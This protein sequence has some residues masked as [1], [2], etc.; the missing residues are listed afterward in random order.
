INNK[1]G[2]EFLIKLFDGI[3]EDD[4]DNIDVEIT[5][6]ADINSPSYYVT[7]TAKG[8]FNFIDK[9]GDKIKSI[10]SVEFSTNNIDLDIIPKNE[11]VILKRDIEKN[12]FES[13]A[14]LEKLFVG[15]NATNVNYVTAEINTSIIE[16]GGSYLVTLIAK[17]GYKI[18]DKHVVVSEE[19]TLPNVIDIEEELLIP[20]DITHLDI[21]DKGYE[22]FNFL[23][24]I[25]V[26]IDKYENEKHKI[27]ITIKNVETGSSVIRP[28][29][30]YTITLTINNNDYVFLD[31]NQRESSEITSGIFK[32]IPFNIEISEIKDPK[33]GAIDV[34]DNA[35]KSLETLQKVFNGVNDDNYEYFHADITGPEPENGGGTNHRIVLIAKK[36]FTINNKG[37]VVSD[38]FNLPIISDLIINARE[39]IDINL[40]SIDIE[41]LKENNDLDL[42]NRLFEGDDLTEANLLNIN[43]EIIEKQTANGKTYK[44]VLEPMPGLTINGLRKL[45]SIEFKVEVVLEIKP[46]EKALILSSK[47]IINETYK[48]LP[49]LEKLF[50]G[51]D[52]S[53]FGNFKV[54]I[55]NTTLGSAT[56]HTIT[57]EA[58]E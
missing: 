22:D 44:V 57:L 40:T 3:E 18:N 10:D 26:G 8:E 36:G 56:T 6:R 51:V 17:D 5:P 33:L 27:D 45:E 47:D 2:I 24:K 50:G 30:S 9:D 49:T 38:D 46:T 53:N 28:L 35:Y 12:N 31:S 15:I 23:N 48:T 58:N 37:T 54:I 16:F 52:A 25:F 7:L 11:P 19:F 20:N 13:L 1:D 41:T 43:L 42:L 29:A 14:T 4:L 55:D 34:W 32:L 21:K 39:E